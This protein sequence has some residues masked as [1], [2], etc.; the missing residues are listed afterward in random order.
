MSSLLG[1]LE[2]GDELE[3]LSLERRFDAESF[4]GNMVAAG[5]VRVEGGAVGVEGCFA[6]RLD[7]D[8]NLDLSKGWVVEDFLSG[9]VI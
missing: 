7:G 2:D 4:D 5:D 8:R 6:G 9:V 3:G 1:L